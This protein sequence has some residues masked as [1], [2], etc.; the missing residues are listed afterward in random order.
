MHTALGGILA[1]A[2]KRVILSPSQEESLVQRM[3]AWETD[4]DAARRARAVLLLASRWTNKAV[5]AE[6]GVAPRQ[7]RDWGQQVREEARASRGETR[8][9]VAATVR[10]IRGER[11]ETVA[12]E[13][14]VPPSTVAAW[15]DAFF[16]GGHRA[17]S[18][19]LH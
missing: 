11:L 9:G 18:R 7:V 4:L 1:V 5:A 15:R 14:K 13:L 8:P 10:L 3:L 12:A 2:T 16:E 6:L 19:T 17:L